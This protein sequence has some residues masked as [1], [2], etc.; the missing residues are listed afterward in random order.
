MFPALIAG[1]PERSPGGPGG[2]FVGSKEGCMA[3]IDPQRPYDLFM[4]HG[5][6]LI[7]KQPVTK[8]DIG[9]VA[10]RILVVS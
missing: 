3:E 6:F 5:G 2:L 1:N 7:I 9:P 4:D 8:T 10:G